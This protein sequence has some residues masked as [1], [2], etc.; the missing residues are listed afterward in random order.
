MRKKS[1]FKM[2]VLSTVLLLLV[3]VGWGQKKTYKPC[4]ISLTS[5]SKTSGVPGDTF[6]MY[7]TWG[8]TQGTKIPCINKGGMNK[9]IV[10]SWSN[11]VIKV[12][13]PAGL[14]PGNYKVGVYCNDLSAGGSYSSGWKDFVINKMVAASQDIDISDIY[15]DDKCRLW[16]KHTN[17]GSVRLNIVLRERVWV[18]G[19]MIDDSRETIVL[20][21]GR[22]ITHGVLA[23]PGYIVRG[24]VIVKAQIDVDNVLIES[25]ETN[26]VLK[27]TVR[28]KKL[29]KQSLPQKMKVKQKK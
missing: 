5:L 19:R 7:G 6:K 9:L 23:D 27:K 18:N 24:S 13:I 14:A 17:R 8:A 11:T 29:F 28:C 25:N 26:N 4:G 15:L 16:L 3:T 22:W 10:L 12:K 21:P 2:F 20:D 1:A